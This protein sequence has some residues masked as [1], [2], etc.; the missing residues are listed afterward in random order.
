M[1]D[2]YLSEWRR[3]E[4]YRLKL[5]RSTLV[6]EKNDPSPPEPVYKRVTTINDKKRPD[7]SKRKKKSYPSLV[8]LNEYLNKKTDAEKTSY[9]RGMFEKIKMLLNVN[10]DGSLGD[11]GNNQKLRAI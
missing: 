8:E 4:D 6:L 9:L 3:A 2:N 5:G 7:F 11:K 10:P 1:V